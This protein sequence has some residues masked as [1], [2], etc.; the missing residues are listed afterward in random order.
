MILDGKKVRDEILDNMKNIIDKDNLDITLAIILIGDNPASKVYVK[1]KILACDKV[2]IKVKLIEKDYI[3]ENELIELI[4]SLNN[5]NNITGILLQSPVPG[6]IDFEKV[7]DNIDSKKDV[8]GFTKKSFY[9]LAHKHKGIRPCTSKGIIRLLDYYNIDLEGKNVC[10]VGRGDIVGKPLI[11]ELLNKNATVTVCHS[12][13]DDLK[14]HTL[15]SDIVIM[16][17]GKAHLL[18]ED[19]VKDEAVVVDCGISFID[20][21]QVGDA[22]FDSMVSKCSYITPNPGGV[23]PMTIAMIIENLVEMKKGE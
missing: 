12:K 18:T 9:N 6:N 16:A 20:G 2:G 15:S 22:D 23:G 5:D 10:I 13:T 17:C 21:H 7:V 14:K 8:D 1:N 4:T 11:F 19:M 3:N